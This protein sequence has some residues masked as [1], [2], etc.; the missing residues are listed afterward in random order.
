M[1]ATREDIKTAATKPPATNQAATNQA[2]TN[3]A[4]TNRAATNQAA[5]KAGSTSPIADPILSVGGL[6]FPWKT[7]DPFLFCVHHDDKY[8]AGNDALG[9]AAS[10]AGRTMGMDFAGKDGWRMYHGRAVPGFP[11]HPHRGFETISIVRRGHI[12]HSDSLGATARIGPGDV[13]WM[14]AG[15]GIVHSEMFPLL[16]KD[17]TNPCEFFQLWI[18]LPGRNKMVPPAFKMFWA[19]E[20]PTH[21]FHDAKSRATKVTIV[22]GELAAKKAPEPPEHSWAAA[23]GSDVAIYRVQ[24]ADEATWTLPPAPAGVNRVIYVFRGAGAQIASRSVMGSSM[25]V[26]HPQAAIPI[27][28]PKGGAELLV[29]QG[30]PIGEPVAQRGPFVMNTWDEIQTAYRDYN[31]TRFGGWPWPNDEPVHPRTSGRFA[32]HANGRVEKA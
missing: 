14:T 6:G 18:N 24:M 25:V 13:Q 8:P 15:R 30:R 3:Q 23:P 17:G 4:A 32:R 20:I 31:R 9:P 16:N 28:A 2:A 1:M 12:D 10:L 26:V 22:A 27:R 21:V 5:T 19:K 29:L 11:Q 7:L